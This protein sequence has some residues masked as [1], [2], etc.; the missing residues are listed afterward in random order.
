MRNGDE[1]GSKECRMLVCD[2]MSNQFYHVLRRERESDA[3]HFVVDTIFL[4]SL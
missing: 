1:M 4:F 2:H 3:A